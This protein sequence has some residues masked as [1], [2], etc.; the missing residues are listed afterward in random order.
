MALR[1]L[2]GVNWVNDEPPWW[3]ALGLLQEWS[4]RVLVS[5]SYIDGLQ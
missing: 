1:L 2:H 5:R 3:I 4:A